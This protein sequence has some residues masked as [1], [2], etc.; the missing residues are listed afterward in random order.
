MALAS[1]FRL[2]I[3]IISLYKPDLTEEDLVILLIKLPPRSIVLLEDIDTA[4]MA[5]E[6]NKDGGISLV[7]LLNTIDS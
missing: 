3:Y 1:T 2:V 6:S 5:R 7:G 4:S